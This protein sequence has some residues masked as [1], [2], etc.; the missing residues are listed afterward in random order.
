MNLVLN[1]PYM[2]GDP[3]GDPEILAHIMKE[4]RYSMRQT[5]PA[6]CGCLFWDPAALFRHFVP[7]TTPKALGKDIDCG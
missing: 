4:A 7:K 1:T 6:L 3:S 2:E 5:F